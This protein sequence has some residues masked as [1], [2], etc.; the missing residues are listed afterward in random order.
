MPEVLQFSMQLKE[1]VR[2]YASLIL[3]FFS[4]RYFS[5]EVECLINM[6]V[7]LEC[8]LFGNVV[9]MFTK[10]STYDSV[11]PR[12]TLPKTIRLRTKTSNKLNLA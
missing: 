10:F 1:D 4:I 5:M 6:F 9:S 11:C 3:F 8:L 7:Y 12:A 2:K